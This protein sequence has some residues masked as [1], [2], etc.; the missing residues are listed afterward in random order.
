MEVRD[1]YQ[2]KG[3]RVV[4]TIGGY[5]RRFSFVAL[6]VTAGATVALLSLAKTFTNSLLDAL[7]V[8]ASALGVGSLVSFYEAFIV[9][10]AFHYET[11]GQ[12]D[13]AEKEA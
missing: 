1:F 12:M 4:F 11:D 5:A 3:V 6:L 10:D 9:R 13:L 7:K 8:P 2:R